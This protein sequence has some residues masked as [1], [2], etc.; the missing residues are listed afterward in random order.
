MKKKIVS[1]ITSSDKSI[2]ISVSLLFCIITV[3]LFVI[4]SY[5]F[6]QYGILHWKIMP[7]VIYL[8]SISGAYELEVETN[9]TPKNV[10]AEKI[11][12]PVEILIKSIGQFYFSSIYKICGILGFVTSILPLLFKPRYWAFISVPF[13]L[14]S[15]IISM[16]IM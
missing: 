15:L 8:N 13:G 7:N 9:K 2:K 12:N 10:L 3:I 11:R 1:F 5:S 16:A 4:S 6:R 14:V